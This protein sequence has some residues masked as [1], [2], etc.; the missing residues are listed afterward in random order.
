[1]ELTLAISTLRRFLESMS[2]IVRAWETFERRD[3]RVFGVNGSSKLRKRW[4]EHVDKVSGH[5]FELGSLQMIVA[6]KLELFN[7]MRDGVS[8]SRVRTLRNHYS[9][10]Q[11]VNAS[12]LRESAAATRQGEF[13]GLLTKMTVVCTKTTPVESSTQLT[14]AQ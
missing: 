13:I 5:V 4:Q 10:G 8:S 7:S 11:V 14:K 6:Q 1:M 3:L 2:R 12:A 9:P